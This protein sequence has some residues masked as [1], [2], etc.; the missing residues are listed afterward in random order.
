ML[1]IVFIFFFPSSSYVS[2]SV[3]LVFKLCCL[4]SGKFAQDLTH[5]HISWPSMVNHVGDHISHNVHFKHETSRSKRS[6]HD[7][8]SNSSK[9]DKAVVHYKIPI[10]REQDVIVRVTRTN[11]ILAPS[12]VLEKKVS[13]F[14]NVSDSAFS[15]LDH[16]H[17]CHYSGDVLGDDGSVVALSACNGL[18]SIDL[19][20]AQFWHLVSHHQHVLF[21]LP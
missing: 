14:K 4:S 13:R 5:F 12:A 19:I 20:T 10:H 6:L 17:G 18:V 21:S 8:L 3:I 7:H 9:T 16:H 1:R 11:L 15:V 2:D